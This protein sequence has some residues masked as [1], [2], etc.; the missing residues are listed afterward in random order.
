VVGVYIAIAVSLTIQGFW[1][2]TLCRWVN[3][4]RR[5]GDFREH[6]T[7]KMKAYCPLKR[8]EVLI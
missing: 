1:D 4:L 8:W 3:T 7:L 2:V 6:L 5:F